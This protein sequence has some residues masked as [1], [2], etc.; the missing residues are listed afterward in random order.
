MVFQRLP[1]KASFTKDIRSAMGERNQP[2]AYDNEHRPERRAQVHCLRQ[3]MFVARKKVEET[4]GSIQEMSD[5]GAI[6]I[7]VRVNDA[8]RHVKNSAISNCSKCDERIWISK[9][10]AES[11]S[12]ETVLT[13]VCTRCATGLLKDDPNPPEIVPFTKEQ[14]E[15]VRAELSDN[16]VD[17]R[18]R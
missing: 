17:E 13:V 6:L 5:E 18:P 7:C 12:A 4:D 3:A 10:S 14:L 11:A 2:P 1:D 15:E 16:N 8:R 9:A